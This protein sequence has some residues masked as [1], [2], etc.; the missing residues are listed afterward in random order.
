M[1]HVCFDILLQ[2]WSSL[3]PQPRPGLRI[4][5][6]RLLVTSLLVFEPRTQHFIRGAN[7]ILRRN[8]TYFLPPIFDW[9]LV[10]GGVVVDDRCWTSN[11]PSCRTCSKASPACQNWLV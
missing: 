1:S 4:V 3:V 7:P 2:K 8:H 5:E 11:L 6:W 9:E 10:F